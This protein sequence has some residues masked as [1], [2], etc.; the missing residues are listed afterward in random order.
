MAA[1]LYQ[2]PSSIG[3]NAGAIKITPLSV[4]AIQPVFNTAENYKYFTEY[5][6]YGSSSANYLASQDINNYLSSY[7]IAPFT[8]NLTATPGSTA[9]FNGLTATVNLSTGNLTLST[10][11][12]AAASTFSLVYYGYTLSSYNYNP[13]LYSITSLSALSGILRPALLPI[14]AVIP[15]RVLSGV[16]AITSLVYNTITPV[17]GEYVTY[18]QVNSA[19][20]T[21]THISALTGNT[22]T[23]TLCFPYLSA[24]YM[25]EPLTA[26]QIK[27]DR[28][29]LNILETQYSELDDIVIKYDFIGIAPLSIV[30][31]RNFFDTAHNWK[32][33]S[34]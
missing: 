9:V 6:S 17:S 1:T 15:I 31:S 22:I 32:I 3:Y 20:T 28:Y 7:K 5:T 21:V 8:T 4:D 26:A 11:T 33:V 18:W 12:F 19:D 30:F 29:L 23:Q 13:F 10:S 34:F 16:P 27:T 2:T 24:I 25:R 14:S